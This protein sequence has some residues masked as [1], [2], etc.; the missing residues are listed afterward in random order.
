M[1]WNS[2]NKS[3]YTIYRFQ[4]LE[5]Y[6]ETL[7]CIIT[8]MLF[9]FLCNLLMK[10]MIRLNFIRKVIW[11]FPVKLIQ[12]CNSADVTGFFPFMKIGCKSFF[13]WTPSVIETSLMFYF[14]HIKKTSLNFSDL[15][16]ATSAPGCKSVCVLVRE[17]EKG[18]GRFKQL[19]WDR[20]KKCVSYSSAWSGTFKVKISKHLIFKK[21]N[22]NIVTP[23]THPAF[24]SSSK[25]E[26]LLPSVK[27]R[28]PSTAMLSRLRSK[29]SLVTNDALHCSGQHNSSLAIVS[30]LRYWS[31]PIP[32][33]S[34]P[35]LVHER[36]HITPFHR[37][38]VSAT[39]TSTK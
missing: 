2:T 5:V 34:A 26:I 31:Y 28:A 18:R 39:H 3:I 21:Y 8:F 4:Q 1:K 14:T 15:L 37:T 23:I 27:L 38:V 32:V 35:L 30:C 6:S 13:G 29:S 9:L 22:V 36:V 17:E 25:A 33:W 11:A 20:P 16:V 24:S 7:S 12:Q 10:K 19:N